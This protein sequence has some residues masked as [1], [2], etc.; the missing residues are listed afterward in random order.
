LRGVGWACDQQVAMEPRVDRRQRGMVGCRRGGKHQ[1][2]LAEKL[3]RAVTPRAHALTRRHVRSVALE[4]RG[5]SALWGTNEP[6]LAN[7][8]VV[9][10]V[11]VLV[12]YAVK[13][14]V[15]CEARRLLPRERIK[16]ERATGNA[17]RRR[18]APKGVDD[19]E[20]HE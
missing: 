17:V 16:E 8:F 19:E 4:K 10:G 12:L 2:V 13:Y 15:D 3:V 18:K 11:P 20:P 6:F 1:R 5:R 9:H 7:L 14:K